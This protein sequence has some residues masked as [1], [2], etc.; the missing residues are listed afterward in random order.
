MSAKPSEADQME[1]ALS[2]IPGMPSGEDDDN[3][4]A[5]NINDPASLKR[6]VARFFRLF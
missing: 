4:L 6:S 5:G 3:P 2:K 1:E